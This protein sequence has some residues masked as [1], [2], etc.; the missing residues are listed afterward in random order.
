MGRIRAHLRG[1]V[2]GYLALFFALSL[3]TAWALAPNSVTSRAIKT[4]A[5]KSS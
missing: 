2:V 3:G 1:N 4:N 5:V